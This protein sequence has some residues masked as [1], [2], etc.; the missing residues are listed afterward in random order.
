MTYSFPLTPPPQIP[1]TLETITI[2]CY[3]KSG[4]FPTPPEP[5]PAPDLVENITACIANGP[6]NFTEVTKEKSCP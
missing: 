3:I 1:V 4:A 2:E 5:I 6:A